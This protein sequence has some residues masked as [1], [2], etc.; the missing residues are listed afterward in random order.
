MDVFLVPLVAGFAIDA[1]SAFTA[2]FSRR[3]GERRGRLATFVLRNLIGIP[4]WVLGLVLAVGS[5]SQQ[6]FEP[7]LI[8]AVLGW[9]LMGGGSVIQVLALLALRSR[10]AMPSTHDPLVEHGPYARIRHPI[11]AAALLEFT[12]IVLLRPTRAVAVAC[13]IGVA[14]ALLQARCEEA[15]L[16]QRLPAYRAYM[17]RVPRFLPRARARWT[18]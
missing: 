2:A 3:W 6:L 8:T 15:D 18:E 10:A 9:L 7:A 12:G 14:W 5:R 11:Y 4:L 16:C 1:A 17:R 13:A